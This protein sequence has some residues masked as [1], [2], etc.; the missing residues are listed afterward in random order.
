MVTGALTKQLP[1]V[2][3]FRVPKAMASKLQ[4]NLAIIWNNSISRAKLALIFKS[5]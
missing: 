2:I 4:E 5:S 3:R 1:N